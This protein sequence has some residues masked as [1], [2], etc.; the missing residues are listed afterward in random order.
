MWSGVGKVKKLM[1]VL[2]SPKKK[3]KKKKNFLLLID[4]TQISK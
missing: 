4:K 2:T 3:K 1:S